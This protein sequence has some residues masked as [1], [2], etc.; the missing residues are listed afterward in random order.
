MPSAPAGARHGRGL[1]VAER[2][3]SRH[4]CRR[5]LAA[6]VRRA[7]RRR[8]RCRARAKKVARFITAEAADSTLQ[9]AADGKLPELHLEEG[10][11][12]RKAAGQ[13]ARSMNPWCCWACWPERRAFDR[14]GAYRLGRA[15]TRPRRNKRPRCGRRSKSSTSAPGTSRPSDLEPYQVLLREAQQAHSRGDFKT[16]R[17]RLPQGAGHA[18]RRARRGREGVDRQPPKR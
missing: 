9:L 1:A 8:H 11:G 2:I 4:R 15:A 14:A 10:R 16:E 5:R 7:L 3:R 13:A 18:P 17:Q 6:D 12:Q